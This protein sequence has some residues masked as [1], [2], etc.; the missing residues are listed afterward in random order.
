MD[1]PKATIVRKVL[2]FKSR[3]FITPHYLRI[4]LSGDVSDFQHST[5]GDNNKIFIPPKGVDQV[6][7]PVMDPSAKKWVYPHLE[8]VPSVRTYTHKGVNL[9]KNELY[10]DFVYHGDNGP[11]SSWA[12]HA[13][14]GDQLG[15][16]MRT[17]P[18]QLYPS[19]A[20]W[21]LLVGDATAIPVLGAI[22][23]D[24]PP[25]AQGVCVIQVASKE[26]IQELPTK[27]TMEFHWIVGDAMEDE[28]RL[29]QRVKDITIASTSKFGYVACEFSAVKEIRRYLRK[30]LKWSS[31]ELYAYSYWKF[32][33]AEDQSARDRQAEKKGIA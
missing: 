4:T 5:I 29:V 12:K 3:Q 22:L 27:A 9:A 20:N 6:Q 25:S 30:E 1:Q 18:K 16:A 15:V 13:K 19:D 28:S 32:G 11:A 31:N 24:L 26:D 17:A 8:K 14:L 21:F 7:F 2:Q 33:V 10:I 23:E